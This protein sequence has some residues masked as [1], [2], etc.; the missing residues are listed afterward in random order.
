M[1]YT[2][3]TLNDTAKA[4]DTLWPGYVNLGMVSFNKYING[5]DPADYN[6]T[7]NYMQGLQNDGTPLANGTTYNFPGDPVTN[8]GEL[9]FDPADR[10]MM[11][12]TGPI[13]FRPGDST[14][15]LA[16]IIFARGGDRL[17]S[18]TVMKYFDVA[19]QDAYDLNFQI[20]K[21]PAAPVVSPAGLNGVVT[22]T[23][24]DTSEVDPGD[25]PFQGYTVFQG[26][27]PSGPWK[28]IGNYDIV[29]GTAIVIDAVLDENTGILEQRAV[30]VATDNG[31]RRFIEIDEN[32]IIGG[33][34]HNLTTYFFKVEAYSLIES[35]TPKTL[36]SATIVEATPQP[37]MAQID[38]PE[39]YADTL[40]VT[41]ASGTSDGSVVPYV[42]D[43]NLLNGHTYEVRF[44][45]YED[46]TITFIPDEFDT[47]I[48]LTPDTTDSICFITFEFDT[49]FCVDTTID[50]VLVDTIEVAHW[51]TSIAD[52]PYWVLVDST[53]G[54]TLLDSMLNQSGDDDY[55]VVDGMLIKVS[56]PENNFKMFEVVANASGTLNPSVSGAASFYGFPTPLDADG[57][58][59]DP[60]AGEQQSTN[61]SRW[62]IH[63]ADNGGSSGGGTRYTYDA[64]LSRT[65]RDGANWPQIIPHDYELRFTG[66]PANPGVNG[67]YCFD[68]YGSGSNV[69]WVPFE[70]WDIGVATPDNSADDYEMVTYLLDADEDETFNLSAY[71]PGG[72]HSVSG[73]DNDPYT[74][75]IY[76]NRPSNTTPGSAGYQAAETEM[77]GGTYTGD[78]ETEVMARMVLVE[79]NG[80]V[81]TPFIAN[82]PETGTIFRIT[83]T[84][85]NNASDVFRFHATQ[86]TVARS[87]D[88][89]D[90]INVV[91]NP[92]YLFGPY[93][94]AVTN[95]QIKFQHLPD[96][97]TIRIFNLAGDLIRTIEKTDG[98]TSIETWDVLTEN[99]LPVAS[100]IYLY[101]VDA[102]GMGQKIGKMAVFME[103]EVIQKY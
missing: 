103:A 69:F 10:R 22:L 42:L 35:K 100:G 23:W 64:F 41:H 50:S 26:E 48:F 31:L 12:S 30:K 86:R 33:S 92:F 4:W 55:Q 70:I 77:L 60:I 40:A 29:D 80:G 9:D 19:A 53:S 44:S 43:P 72:E 5:T 83:S 58:P 34:L 11:Q 27:S 2:G 90:Q 97:C 67:S 101:V 37:K 8:S 84:K 66:S 73:G 76:W 61:N 96:V 82:M 45:A 88:R 7:Y 32:A 87:G 54:D 68:T 59:T 63:T 1:V 39:N 46:S 3:D 79:W 94:P 17:S 56:G 15:I 98:A 57:N 81:D 28:Q 6:E 51:D 47:T 52:V 102:P 13:T 75:W 71:G 16:A 65:A 85:P 21:P 49:I 93:D 14:E 99:G 18:I 78:R 62:L 25:Y 24:G 91:P 20:P 89:L 74:D 38:Y 95:R 36:T